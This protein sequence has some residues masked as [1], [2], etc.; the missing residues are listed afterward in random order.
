MLLAHVFAYNHAVSVDRYRLVGEAMGLDMRGTA[1]KTQKQ[2]VFAEFERLRHAVRINHTL[3]DVGVHRTDIPTLADKAI[4]DA[5]MITNP[6][7]PTQ[8]DIE[9]VYEEAL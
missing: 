1:V 4:K 6:R 9:V 7:Q 2:L 8:R 5:C 3:G